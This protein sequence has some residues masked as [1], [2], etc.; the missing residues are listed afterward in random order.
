MAPPPLP[1]A[2]KKKFGC[3]KMIAIV[4]VGFFALAMI[5]WAM[6]SPEERARIV[7]EQ[8]ARRAAQEKQ[9]SVPPLKT[10][11][12]ASPPPSEIEAAPAP[13]DPEAERQATEAKA[14]EA[15]AR[16]AEK[17]AQAAAREK[18]VTQITWKEIAAVYSLKSKAT[19]I[20]KDEKWKGYKGREVRWTGKVAEVSKDILGNYN[21]SVKMSPDTFTFDVLVKLRK[22]QTDAAFKLSKDDKVTFEAKLDSWGSVMPITA[23]D[24]VIVH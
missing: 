2:P 16:E 24:G 20:V 7:A 12:P 17:K 18:A 10:P 14:K 5:N 3:L 13:V 21:L 1:T 9:A 4:L 11:P 22:D 19:D 15:A 6:K 23:D 8:E